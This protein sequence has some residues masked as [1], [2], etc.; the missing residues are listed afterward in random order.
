MGSRAVRPP[1]KMGSVW[2]RVFASGGERVQENLRG[3][4]ISRGRRGEDLGSKK[5][6]PGN[7]GAGLEVW[8]LLGV[9]FAP[10]TN[11]YRVCGKPAHLGIIA[12]YA[13]A[14]K[15]DLIAIGDGARRTRSIAQISLP[16]LRKTRTRACRIVRREHGQG[17]PRH[18]RKSLA[19]RHCRARGAEST[20]ADALR[21]SNLRRPRA[22]ASR[23]QCGK[24]LR[25]CLGAPTIQTIL[26]S[27]A[28]FSCII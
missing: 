28:R 24:S 26:P 21:Q 14:H 16:T 5:F 2:V 10:D 4:S 22:G 17:R 20:G 27:G 13:P 7:F 19:R 9:A 8:S 12:H 11:Q 6:S 25:P 1:P 3:C 18:S 15:D 23:D